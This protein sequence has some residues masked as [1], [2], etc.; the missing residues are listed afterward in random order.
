MVFLAF[1]ESM[2][3][4]EHLLCCY[5]QKVGCSITMTLS[6]C[7][8]RGWF[9]SP[10]TWKTGWITALSV[11]SLK[12]TSKRRNVSGK[13]FLWMRVTLTG[14]QEGDMDE[15]H[16]YAATR[17]CLCSIEAPWDQTANRVCGCLLSLLL[18]GVLAIL[19]ENYEQA[20]IFFEDAT[21]LEPTNVI[22]WTLLGMLFP[23]DVG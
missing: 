7:V 23:C 14:R 21:C 10:R 12:T 16:R 4:M 8:P 6:L 11:S 20:E 5:A 13:P 19:L 15:R 22:A 9:G 18:C 3:R 1:I 17:P 2:V